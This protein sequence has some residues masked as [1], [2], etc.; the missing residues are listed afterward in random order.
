M[1]KWAYIRLTI[2]F[3]GMVFGSFSESFQ[4]PSSPP[5]GIKGLLIMFIFIPAGVLLM[6]WVQVLNPNSDKKWVS[7]SWSNNPFD[8][9]QPLDF[10][11]LVGYFYLASGIASISIFFLGN[12]F[13]FETLVPILMGCGI[14]LG[15]FISTKVFKNKMGKGL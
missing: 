8:F 4:T 12:A 3:I 15:V 6:V 9:K 7:P 10:F 5:M 2:L 11:N 1:N 13:L 14:L